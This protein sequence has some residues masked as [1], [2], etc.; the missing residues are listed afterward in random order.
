[1]GALAAIGIDDNLAPCQACVAVRPSDNKLA[2]GIHIVLDVKSEEVEHLL[3]MNLL[4]HTGDK[5]I[6]DIVFD[7]CQHLLVLV[8]LVMLGTDDDGV[9]TL[10]DTLI[11]ILDC[12]LTLGVGTQ[13]GHLLPFLADISKRAHDEV[14]QI[15]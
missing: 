11:T 3:T 9:D 4:L 12:H 7:L 1:M 14:C 2:S 10:G 5:D 6:D 13:V 15:E 8:E